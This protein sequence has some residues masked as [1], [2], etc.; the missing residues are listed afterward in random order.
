MVL[1]LV[2]TER[3]NTPGWSEVQSLAMH[4]R[5]SVGAAET[6][7]PGVYMQIYYVRDGEH[8]FLTILHRLHA[9]LVVAITFEANILY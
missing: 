4:T 5:A 9:Y 3:Q 1:A 6:P 8:A 2:V 7:F